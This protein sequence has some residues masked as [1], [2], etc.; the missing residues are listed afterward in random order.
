MVINRLDLLFS[1]VDQSETDKEN[2]PVSPDDFKE[3]NYLLQTTSK[4]LSSLSQNGWA[5]FLTHPYSPVERHHNGSM[6]KGK[7]DLYAT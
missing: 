1:Q 3:C 6:S 7:I 2:T 5:M 4:I